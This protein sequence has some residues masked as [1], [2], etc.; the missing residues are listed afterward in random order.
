MMNIEC[1][2]YGLLGIGFGIP[3]AIGITYLIFIVV[4]EEIV[5][6]FYVPW[7][8]ILIAVGSVFIVV[9]A[10][11]LYSMNKIKKDNVVETLRND[12]A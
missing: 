6:D 4:S 12:V 8:S 9:F 1:L 7:Y 2:R 5:M 10:T 3:V 11:M